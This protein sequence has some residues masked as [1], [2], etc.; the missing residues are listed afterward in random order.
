MRGNARKVVVCRQ[1]GEVVPNAQ[2]REN[3][4][5]SADLDTGPAT[6][7]AQIGR[8]DMVLTL[9]RKNGQGAKS[10]DDLGSIALPREALK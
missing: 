4:V 8:V 7:V 9:R 5:D 3:R 2:L 1:Q 6:A 10:I